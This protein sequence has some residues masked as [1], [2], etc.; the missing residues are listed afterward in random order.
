MV[1]NQ[2]ILVCSSTKVMKYLLPP[3][4]ETLKGPHI[5]KCKTYRA[6]FDLLS[7]FDAKD[8][9]LFFHFKHVSHNI[10]FAFN[11]GRP[12]TKFLEFSSL[13]HLKFKWLYLIHLI[14]SDSSRV[15]LS[16]HTSFA[17]W[18]LHLNI[19]S[20]EKMDIINTFLWV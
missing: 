13:M 4:D 5:S 7:M 8:N 6:S 14:H 16:K 15:M 20:F 19:I 10:M 18:M 11:L 9:I 3:S 12:H 17:L 2:N 1:Y